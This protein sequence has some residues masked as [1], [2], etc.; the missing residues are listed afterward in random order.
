MQNR[1]A[2]AGRS[3]F[4]ARGG[5][6]HLKQIAFRADNA[7]L[8]ICDLDALR[9]RAEMVAAVTAAID[10]NPLPCR[11]GECLDHLR[12]DGLLR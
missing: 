12:R 7:D 9:K 8:A 2:N 11:S 10:P 5:G 3:R 1:T 6:E 4:H